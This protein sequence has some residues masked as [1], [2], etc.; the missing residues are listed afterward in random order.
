MEKGVKAAKETVGLQEG[1][2][3]P[4]GLKAELNGSSAGAADMRKSFASP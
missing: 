1:K 2:E 3:A 4:G